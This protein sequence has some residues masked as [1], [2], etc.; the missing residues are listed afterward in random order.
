[1]RQ[2]PRVNRY[3]P[4]DTANF[5]ADIVAFTHDC[6]IRVLHTLRINNQKRGFFMTSLLAMCYGHLI[7]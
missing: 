2:T 1:M 3:M 5:L 7:F 6:S 4:I